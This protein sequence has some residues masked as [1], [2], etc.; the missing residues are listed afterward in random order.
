LI[1]RD[2][3]TQDDLNLFPTNDKINETYNQELVPDVLKYKEIYPLR[4]SYRTTLFKKYFEEY[5]EKG[6]EE[7]KPSGLSDDDIEL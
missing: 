5:K 7:I 6:Q 4:D 2:I 1:V 3:K